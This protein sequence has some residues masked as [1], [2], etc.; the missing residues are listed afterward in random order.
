MTVGAA[1]GGAVTLIRFVSV[2]VAPAPTVPTRFKV[3]VVPGD[4]KGT[5]QSKVPRSKVPDPFVLA[6]DSVS[7]AAAIPGLRHRWHRRCRRW[8]R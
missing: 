8:T 7:P 1:P 5:V 4:T 6:A 3:A 2:P